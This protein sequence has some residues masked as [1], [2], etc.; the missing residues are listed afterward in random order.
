MTGVLGE[1]VMRMRKDSSVSVLTYAF[2]YSLVMHLLTV[3]CV[4]VPQ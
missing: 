1:K 4:A 3:W 2:K